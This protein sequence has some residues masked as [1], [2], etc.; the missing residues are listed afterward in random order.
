VTD[1]LNLG[2]LL[3]R[4][5]P[6]HPAI[7]DLRDPG[8]PRTWSTGQLDQAANAVARGLLR[9]GLEPGARVGILSG[10]RAEFLAAYLG[11]MRAGLVTV[12]INHRLPPDTVGFIFQDAGIGVTFVDSARRGLVPTAAAV[13]ELDDT[14]ETGFEALLDPG[15]FDPVRPTS[16]QIAKILYTSGST[17]R[18]KGVPLPH[19]GQL[20]ALGKYWGDPAEGRRDRT[21]VV[22]PTYHKNGLYFSMMALANQMTIVS[23]S[24]F[25]A[26]S[27]LE[28]V[29]EYRCTVLTGIPTMFAL[30]AREPDLVAQLDFSAVRLVTIGSAP[31]TDAL[32]A[33]VSQI[34]PNAEVTNGYGT[35]E[36]GPCAF[37]PHPD[38]LARPPLALGYPFPD[39]EW[40]LTGGTSTEG[41]LELKTPALTPGYLNLPKATAERLREGW[42]NTGDIVRH[43][44]RGFFFFVGRADD[45]FVCGGENVYPGEVEKLLERHP[46]V[47]EAVVVPVADEIKGQIPV[48]FVVPV[49]GQTPTEPDLKAWTLQQGPAYAHPR[50]FLFVDRI[51]VAT[52]HKVDRRVL[53]DQATKLIRDRGRT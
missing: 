19:A 25:D 28:T 46:G 29:A 6:D 2:D 11:T 20:W 27:Y 33:K 41:V 43:D 13:V 9:R 35:T 44:E 40:R 26:R 4:E 5:A 22:A 48:A 18:P 39:L 10:N 49:P 14:G 1:R 47:A 53:I 50:G 32:L 24:G 30:I 12:P 37:G 31:L 52:T 17:G 34:F 16:G 38:G 3:P 15:P 36:A 23:R 21:L 7:I 45:M 42:Y 51:P 8:T